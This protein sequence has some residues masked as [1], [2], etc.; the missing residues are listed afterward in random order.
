MSPMTPLQTQH[1]ASLNMKQGWNEEIP[2]VPFKSNAD[3]EYLV[4]SAFKGLAHARP[5]PH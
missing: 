5:P 4:F 3:I 1:E 2:E